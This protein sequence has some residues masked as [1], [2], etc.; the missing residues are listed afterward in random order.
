MKDGSNERVNTTTILSENETPYENRI[1]LIYYPN[2][3]K[4]S[5][6]YENIP[7]KDNFIYDLQ[8]QVNV[9][10]ED[11][12]FNEEFLIFTCKVDLTNIKLIEKKS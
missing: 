6:I 8:F 11:N 12:I 10:I 7:R 1:K 9:I 5:L 2:M 4:W 3:T